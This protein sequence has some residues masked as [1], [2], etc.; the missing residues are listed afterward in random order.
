[1]SKTK[2]KNS[3]K[4]SPEAWLLNTVV[5]LA[6]GIVTTLGMVLYMGW[7]STLKTV[8][9]KGLFIGVSV[10]FLAVVAL[11]L[12][13]NL[14]A[15][16]NKVPLN[17][18]EAQWDLWASYLILAFL[19]YILIRSLVG[20]PRCSAPKISLSVERALCVLIFAAYFLIPVFF[21][22]PTKTY[23]VAGR[24]LIWIGRLLKFPLPTVSIWGTQ[25][26]GVPYFQIYVLAGTVWIFPSFL[27]WAFL[28]G[29]ELIKIKG[30]N[31]SWKKAVYEVKPLGSEKPIPIAPGA[32]RIEIEQMNRHTLALGTTGS[33]KTS[34][35]VYLAKEIIRRGYGILFIDPKGDPSVAGAL[36]EVCR[37]VGRE[38]D[39][40]WLELSQPGLSAT[41]NP[42]LRSDY[43]ILANAIMASKDWS[44]EFYK[45]RA[46]LA[47]LVLFE[48]F[49]KLGLSVTLGDIY[50]IL[51]QRQY[52][53]GLAKRV[54]DP[55]L[56]R[57]L[58]TIGKCDAQE[59]S[60][61]MSYLLN[62]D[63]SFPQTR[64]TAPSLD[65][66]DAYQNKKVV[67]VGLSA[68]AYKE[69]AKS[70]GRLMFN[71]LRT[72]TSLVEREKHRK[73]PFAVFIDE[74]GSIL[75]Q[76][77]IFWLNQCRSAG[78]MACL[79]VQSVADL[80]VISPE[81]K[82]QVFTN[83]N[84]LISFR[85]N[86][87]AT[88]D[89][90][91]RT[92]GTQEVTEE[93]RAYGPPGLF[94]GHE[95]VGTSEREVEQFLLHP[96]SIK[97][98]EDGQAAVLLRGRKIQYGVWPLYRY[99]SNQHRSFQDMPPSSKQPAVQFPRLSVKELLAGS[100]SQQELVASF[101]TERRSTSQKPSLIHKPRL[102]LRGTSLQ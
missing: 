44:N 71:D 17:I 46:F 67:Y 47:L 14:N 100:D 70:L 85:P 25:K 28:L 98:L 42:L 92:I 97:E 78:F 53:A 74:A 36:S 5:D 56:A 20:L 55:L 57:E 34:F 39:F 7:K 29:D 80:E 40:S 90:I 8:Q 60:G 61:L 81:F 6:I 58:I 69:T 11:K 72:V 1:M 66:L 68:N 95:H 3:G 94:F 12:F 93:T 30:G 64:T 79:G 63:R 13:I 84:T 4:E 83:C 23:D 35:M 2:E 41:Y 91:A 31:T 9:R 22:K 101:N 15:Y 51:S 24:N 19:P 49:Q 43:S 59:F 75:P 82:K 96:Q 48:A 33:G 45:D 77:A 62:L 89:E 18:T 99:H 26:Q 21:S 76:D 86:D 32:P 54:G 65:F 10:V 73:T 27:L 87:Y 102:D 37:G 38:K 16:G 88:A 52:L 50:E